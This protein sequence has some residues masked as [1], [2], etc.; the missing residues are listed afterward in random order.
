ML[1]YY[2]ICIILFYTVDIVT[3]PNDLNIPVKNKLY[4]LV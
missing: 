2:T 4:R 1:Y 3:R